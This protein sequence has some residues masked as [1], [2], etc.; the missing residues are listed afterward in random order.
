[1]SSFLSCVWDLHAAVQRMPKR[2]ERV[3]PSNVFERA[4]VA[5]SCTCR[6]FRVLVEQHPIFLSH[7]DLRDLT[8]L[9]RGGVSWALRYMKTHNAIELMA[10]PRREGYYLYRA[11]L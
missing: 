1:M 5:D 7:S 11:V 8:G 3:L 6:V 4:I 10:H 9:N 2:A